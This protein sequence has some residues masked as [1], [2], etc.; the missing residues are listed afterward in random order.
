[1]ATRRLLLLLCAVPGSYAPR[2]DF[3]TTPR[4]VQ[5]PAPTPVVPP[6][7]APPP[8]PPPTP[9]PI[10]ASMALPTRWCTTDEGCRQYGDAGA[11]CI[12]APKESTCLCSPTAAHVESD[13]YVASV[14]IPHGAPPPLLHE[15]VVVS[16]FPDGDCAGFASDGVHVD[17]LIAH[18]E[19]VFRKRVVSYVYECGSVHFAATFEMTPAELSAF[20]LRDVQD[21]LHGAVQLDSPL[22][23][24]LGPTPPSARAV[25]PHPSELGCNGAQ[26]AAT[27]V[28]VGKGCAPLTCDAGYVKA[29][30]GPSAPSQ[31]TLATTSATQSCRRDGDCTY[32]ADAA[33]CDAAT[34]MCAPPAVT[35]EPTPAMTAAPEDPITQPPNETQPP[36]TAA[37]VTP[38]PVS[39]PL[40]PSGR[41]NTKEGINLENIRWCKTD[42]DCRF[43]GDALAEC[44]GAT[45]RCVCKTEGYGMRWVGKVPQ[46]LCA[47]T[48]SRV[49]AVEPKLKMV[50]FSKF[51]DGKCAAFRGRPKGMDRILEVLELA[52][53]APIKSWTLL[54]GSANFGIEVEKTTNEMEELTTITRDVQELLVDY[55]DVSESLGSDIGND[56][57]VL[58]QGDGE[59]ICMLPNAKVTSEFH[60]PSGTF[61]SVNE[62]HAEYVKNMTETATLCVKFTA[63]PDYR[64]HVKSDCGGSSQCVEVDGPG[65]QAGRKCTSGN[66]TGVEDESNAGFATTHVAL[67]VLGALLPV[68]FC[69]GI[70]WAIMR[71]SPER[72]P[73][74]FS[75]A[76]GSTEA[77][78]DET[79]A[80]KDGTDLVASTQRHAPT[81]TACPDDEGDAYRVRP[82][83]PSDRRFAPDT[84]QNPLA[85]VRGD[86]GD[87]A[88]LPPLHPRSRQSTTDPSRTGQTVSS[89]GQA[90]L[91]LLR[92]KTPDRTGTSHTPVGETMTQ[93]NITHHPLLPIHSQETL[94]R[95]R[96]SDA[97]ATPISH[98]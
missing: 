17:A 71:N 51:K 52:L 76:A 94:C 64:C 1:M 3:V 40:Q 47:P 14:C 12:W 15:V 28:S 22:A 16:E 95:D 70:R 65:S 18:H 30:T 58:P 78:V 9:A 31:C 92:S 74:E 79:H 56:V 19:S 67:T 26:H 34:G 42:R 69:L 10:P 98:E 83:Q 33:V 32:T 36:M 2:P 82:P 4:P 54:C 63:V 66:E 68:C 87:R 45:S 90:G 43:L 96:S 6:T 60:L 46:Y 39:T 29:V 5:I 55:P 88:S 75:T 49:G 81:H 91:Y 27:A 59:S 21:A 89:G 38:S 13:G 93:S 23:T 48:L 44:D 61:C 41:P 62:C 80:E 25:F 77:A 85:D 84:L 86:D 72:D 7:P 57:S 73:E 50:V 24:V 20:R 37:P 11:M 35:P 53:K 8:P 97:R